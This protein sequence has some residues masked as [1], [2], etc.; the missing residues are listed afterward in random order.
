MT[1]AFEAVWPWIVIIIAAVLA[2][3]VLEENQRVRRPVITGLIL[4]L[5]TV[6]VC[7]SV[8]VLMS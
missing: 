5:T 2:G 8:G 6:V 3:L 4:S 1:T 7:L